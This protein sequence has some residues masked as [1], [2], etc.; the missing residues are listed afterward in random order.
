[1]SKMKI[2]SQDF[3]DLVRPST[4]EVRPCRPQSAVMGVYPD[5]PHRESS[6]INSNKGHSTIDRPNGVR[7]ALARLTGSFHR[8]QR[9]KVNL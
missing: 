3:L 1:M 8:D 4:P 2:S 5:H 7:C 6:P 9:P